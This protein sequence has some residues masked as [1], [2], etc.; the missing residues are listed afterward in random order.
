MDDITIRSSQDLAS[1]ERGFTSEPIDMPEADT[2][3]QREYVVHRGDFMNAYRQWDRE[4]DP[5]LRLRDRLSGEDIFLS[6]PAVERIV[7]AITRG[8]AEVNLDA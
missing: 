6:H 3:D 7:A 1:F 4:R 8:S 5:L 2:F